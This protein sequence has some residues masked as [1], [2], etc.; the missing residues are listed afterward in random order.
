M[1]NA[2]IL[3][4]AYTLP[5]VHSRIN[6][7]GN[8]FS[9]TLCKKKPYRLTELATTAKDISS[10]TPWNKKQ[11]Q[12]FTPQN[13]KFFPPYRKYLAKICAFSK[14]YVIRIFPRWTWEWLPELSDFPI[15]ILGGWEIMNQT[16][17]SLRGLLNNNFCGTKLCEAHPLKLAHSYDEMWPTLAI[18]DHRSAE[19]RGGV[20]VCV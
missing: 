8:L 16:K 12:L 3:V 2:Y 7:D 20:V 18:K 4:H 15:K 9:N 6:N 19:N 5:P 10:S 1:A 13:T 14:I 17:K 11:K